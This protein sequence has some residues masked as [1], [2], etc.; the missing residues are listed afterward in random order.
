MSFLALEMAIA[1]TAL[2]KHLS[3]M[4]LVV[5]ELS[6]PFLYIVAQGKI[7]YDGLDL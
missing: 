4:A 3:V 2:R 7:K 1:F 5:L 6:R